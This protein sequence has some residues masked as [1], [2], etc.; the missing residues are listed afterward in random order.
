MGDSLDMNT[1]EQTNDDHSTSVVDADVFIAYLKKL[2]VTLLQENG[3][4]L[5]SALISTLEDRTHLEAIKKFISDSQVS[6]LFIQRAI[7]KGKD[8]VCGIVNTRLELNRA[9]VA[10]T[11]KRSKETKEMKKKNWSRFTY[12]TACILRIR[13]WR[14]MRSN[15]VPGV[16]E[17]NLHFESL[18]HGFHQERSGH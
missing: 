3:E 18:Q 6:S 2:V 15:N 7:T 13:K 17:R 16:A 9:F 4:D 12:R 1:V 10:Q 11:K 14:G 5:T 8:E